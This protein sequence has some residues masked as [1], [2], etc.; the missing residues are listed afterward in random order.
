MGYERIA[1]DF[2]AGRGGDV[3]GIGASDV[4]NWVRQLQPGA[5]VLDLGCG[6]GIPLS[7][8][9][10][11]EGMTVYG[12]DASPAMIET[13]QGN[14]PDAPVI[15]EA[16]ED[17]LFFGRKFDGIIAWGLV[18]LLPECKQA[19]LFKRVAD[20]I[21]SGGKLLFTAPDQPASWEDRM[22]GQ[23]S[24]SLGAERYGQLLLSAGFTSIEGFEGEGG[25]YHYSA[26]KI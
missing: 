15:C 2:I 25:N 26:T 24:V 20:A 1:A 16:I 7:K 11:E 9:L 17:S 23:V 10:V 3:N 19:E 8:V 13:F 18:F 5:T 21:L 12:L 4:R 6:T 14:F 22:T